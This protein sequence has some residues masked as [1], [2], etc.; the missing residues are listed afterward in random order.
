MFLYGFLDTAKNTQNRVSFF[1]GEIRWT[2]FPLYFP[3]LALAKTPIPESMILIGGLAM[4]ITQAARR[5]WRHA[6]VIAP[7]ALYFTCAVV[8]GF[9][10]GHRHI[11]PIYPFLLVSAGS[12]FAVMAR[13][14]WSTGLIAVCLGWLTIGTLAAAPNYIAYFNEAVGG[15]RGGVNVV[16]DSSLD[17]GQDLPAL[18]QWMTKENVR[19]V[20]LSYF[21]T[22]RPEAYDIDYIALPSVFGLTRPVSVMD[23]SRARYVAV[24]ATNL[25]GLYMQYPYYEPFV[26]KLAHLRTMSKPVAVLGGSIYVY[27]LSESDR[28][29]ISYA[30]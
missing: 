5:M 26:E 3:L 17:W 4:A 24:S 12:V 18:K 23:P 15:S 30:K 13:R 25:Q 14:T 28:A 2:G 19:T 27:D 7:A 16:V 9:N 10:I 6:V 8:N 20:Y 1:L 22:A 21:G 29:A 11:L